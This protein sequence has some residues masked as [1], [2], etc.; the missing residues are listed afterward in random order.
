M[1]HTMTAPTNGQDPAGS[2]GTAAMAQT[3]PKRKPVPSVA[4]TRESYQGSHHSGS[5][6]TTLV[7]G[8]SASGATRGMSPPMMM[9]M[10][11]Q[12]QPQQYYPPP[13]QHQQ[14]QTAVTTVLPPAP[15]SIGS[16]QDLTEENLR[17]ARLAHESRSSFGTPKL[18][19]QQ[20]DDAVSDIS[21]EAGAKRTTTKQVDEMSD[22]SSVGEEGERPLSGKA[23]TAGRKTPMG[24]RQ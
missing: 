4:V 16:S 18:H 9:M 3:S 23:S 24:S 19:R 6:S 20:S 2:F 7:N 12:T 22:V 1:K 5:L 11:Q 8:H 13:P 10:A 15:R 14:Q 17:I 21:N